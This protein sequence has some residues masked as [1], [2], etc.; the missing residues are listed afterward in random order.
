MLIFMPS[1]IGAILPW[2]SEKLADISRKLAKFEDAMQAKLREEIA[3]QTS[4]K[5][6]YIQEKAKTSSATLESIRCRQHIESMREEMPNVNERLV[7]KMAH[8]LMKRD[9]L[10]SEI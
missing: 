6:L 9:I 2:F 4:V 3:I 5:N 10:R 1:R 7:S 8:A